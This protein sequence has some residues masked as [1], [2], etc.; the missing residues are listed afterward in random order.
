MTLGRFARRFRCSAI[1]TLLLIAGSP[2]LAFAQSD[3]LH[4]AAG[5]R[6]QLT[7][8]Q[9]ASVGALIRIVRES[10]G[11][12]QDPAAAEGEG[13]FLQFGCVSGS[14]WGAMGLHF[15]NGALVGDG[16]IDVAR[17]VFRIPARRRRHDRLDA[18]A[19]R[20]RI[21][22]V[23]VADGACVRQQLPER[24]W[25]RRRREGPHPALGLFIFAPPGF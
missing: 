2:A 17:P 24:D 20:N 10:T 22:V 12:F 6:Q 3:H 5:Q 14:D 9:K 11:R 13:Y 25:P 4:G 18:V 7:A 15:I 16:E 19:E 1:G 23:M 8:D 21:L